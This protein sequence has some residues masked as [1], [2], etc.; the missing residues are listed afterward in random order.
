[1][2]QYAFLS[3]DQP[4]YFNVAA[5]SARGLELEATARLSSLVRVGATTTLLRTRVDDAGLQTGEDATFV[6]GN[7]LLRRPS[8]LSTGTVAF[9]LSGGTTLDLAVTYTG[10]RDDRDFATFPATPVVLPSWTRVDLGFV[11]PLSFGWTR[12]RLDLLV[13][14]ENLFGSNYDEIVNY[15]AGRRLL[16]LGIRAASVR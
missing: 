11:R 8:V 3:A 1:M 14:V 6:E 15:P 16:T 7:R 12:A 4:N 2:I 5:A 13:R 9:D 10:E